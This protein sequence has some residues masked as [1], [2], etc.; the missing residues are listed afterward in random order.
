MGVSALT[1]TFVATPLTTQAVSSQTYSFNSSAAFN[2]DT[3]GGVSFSESGTQSSWYDPAWGYRQRITINHELVPGTLTDFPLLVR[4]DESLKDKARDDRYDLLLTSS[5][6]TTKLSHELEDSSTVWVK[7]PT[8]KSDEDTILYLYYGNPNAADQQNSSDVWSNGYAAVYHLNDNPEGDITDS[9][10]NE[11]NGTSSGGMQAGKALQEGK[12]GEALEFDGTN[13]YVDVGSAGL[14]LIENTNFSVSLWV[15]PNGAIGGWEGFISAGQ[16]APYSFGI[17]TSGGVA[18][19]RGLEFYTNGS[20]LLTNFIPVSDTW[21]HIIATFDQAVGRKIYIDGTL[22]KSDAYTTVIAPDSDRMYIGVDY[23][24]SSGRNFDGQI[25]EVGIANTARSGDWIKTEYVNQC[26][27][28][29]FLTINPDVERSSTGGSSSLPTISLKS[30]KALSFKSLHS[31]TPNASPNVTYQLSNNAGTTWYVYT[32]DGWK[33]ATN[34][35]G[36][37]AHDITNHL[38]TFPQGAGRL[39]W[40]AFLPSEATLNS[41]KIDY[42]GG[43][44]ITTTSNGTLSDN[45][46]QL[47]R[48]AYQREITPLEWTVWATRFTVETKQLDAWLGAMEWQRIFGS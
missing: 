42:T 36:S 37:S 3:S 43:G 22:N 29:D 38:D 46:N 40:K 9:T 16:T 47:F 1:L 6:G 23:T 24:S 15:K 20:S 18:G 2:Y 7:V 25:D 34:Q 12:V 4:L 41:L 14:D 28:E 10:K 19:F 31:F 35:T 30:S 39:T 48:T 5:D 17:R 11:N 8:L 27:C 44:T 45:I 33:V 26:D 13:D 21:F 32:K